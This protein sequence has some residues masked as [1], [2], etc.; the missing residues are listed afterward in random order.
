MAE[1]VLW[2][3][4]SDACASGGGGGVGGGKSTRGRGDRKKSERISARV[5]GPTRQD[6]LVGGGPFLGYRGGH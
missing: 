4:P 3:R 6:G 5:L 2:P 1:E